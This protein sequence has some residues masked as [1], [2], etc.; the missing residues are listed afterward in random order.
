M[1]GIQP[2]ALIVS[3]NR[4]KIYYSHS[5]NNFWKMSFG[6]SWNDTVNYFY[7]IM[8]SKFMTRFT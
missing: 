8:E 6:F 7:Y 5:K 2:M 3:K 1:I 4:K